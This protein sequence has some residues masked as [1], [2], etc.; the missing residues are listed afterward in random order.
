M[1]DQLRDAVITVGGPWPVIGGAVVLL[2]FLLWGAWMAR[3]QSQPLAIGLAGAAGGVLLFVLI[4]VPA[5]RASCSDLYRS[6][7]VQ[8]GLKHCQ[9]LVSCVGS[10][11][12]ASCA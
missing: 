7:Q 6:D 4:S 12:S 3:D 11:P 8:F 5:A 9:L 10:G 1:E 2:A